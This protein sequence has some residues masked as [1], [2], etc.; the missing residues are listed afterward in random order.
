MTNTTTRVIPRIISIEGPIGAGKSTILVELARFYEEKQR[1][2]IVIMREP[3][4][5]WNSVCGED[6]ESIIQKFYK[7]PGKYSFA[8]QTLICNTIVQEMETIIANNPECTTI[9]CER[10]LCAS[11]YVFAKMLYD[12]NLFEKALYEIYSMAF[13]QFAQGFVATKIVYLDCPPISCLARIER[14]GRTGEDRISIDYLIKCERYYINWMFSTK[15]PML[16]I[17]VKKDIDIL[18]H[19]Y[20]SYIVEIDDFIKLP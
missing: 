13:K 7:N 2:D 3:V 17:D 16:T 11:K 18:S 6:G 14:R 12:D 20:K 5:V 10:S 8:F 1:T 9:I 4:E 15:V 19:I